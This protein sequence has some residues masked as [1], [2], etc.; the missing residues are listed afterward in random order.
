MLKLAFY[1][2]AALVL[3]QTGTWGY[4]LVAYVAWEFFKGAQRGGGIAGGLQAVALKAIC[5]GLVYF[6]LMSPA[7]TGSS[8]LLMGL[9]GTIGLMVQ[10]FPT[11]KLRKQLREGME[12]DKTDDSAVARRDGQR[13]TGDAVQSALEKGNFDGAADAA[14]K[15]AEKDEEAVGRVNSSEEQ[16]D[17]VRDGASR[18]QAA[19]GRQPGGRQGFWNWFIN[20]SSGAGARANGKQGLVS[21]FLFGSKGAPANAKQG[22]ASVF[23]NGRQQPKTGG[24]LGWFLFGTPVKKKQKR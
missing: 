5:A 14:R 21:W 8:A 18:E 9:A 3:W 12:A 13:R 10:K 2:I 6:A 20:G 22:L 16:L 17:G 4:A 1:G 23:L 15:G 11:F 19:Q 24:W 7:V